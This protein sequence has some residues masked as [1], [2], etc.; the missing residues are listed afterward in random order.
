MDK[1]EELTNMAL[2][3]K[4][5]IRIEARI[6]EK[7]KKNITNGNGHKP[8][9]INQINEEEPD[10]NAIQGKNPKNQHKNEPIKCTFCKKSGHPVE[11]CFT[12]FPALKP[13][14]YRQNNNQTKTSKQYCQFCEKEGH[15]T[16][17]CFVME[18][19]LKRINASNKQIKINS[20]QK[21]QDETQSKN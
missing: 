9:I 21:Q 15:P 13:Q 12:K 3:R 6:E 17:K 18:K 16:D 20:M 19:T 4:E 5:A 14:N 11:R 1:Q 10:I 8:I 7:K 2:I